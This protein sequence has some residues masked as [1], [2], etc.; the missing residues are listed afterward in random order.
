MDE[1]S[2]LG[3]VYELW[4]K[5]NDLREMEM[6]RNIERYCGENT[7]SRGV[8]L[9]GAAHRQHIIEKSRE[10]TATAS[11]QIQWDFGDWLSQMTR[12]SDG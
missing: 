12:V 3:T 5:T 9:V 6:V 10:Q 11:T 8:F 1:H 7:F 2:R 4:A